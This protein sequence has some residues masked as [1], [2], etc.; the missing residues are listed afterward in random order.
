MPGIS[1]DRL[2]RIK[3]SAE[4]SIKSGGHPYPEDVT[5]E[6]VIALVNFVKNAAPITEEDFRHLV[7][8][9]NR[10]EVFHNTAKRLLPEEEFDRITEEAEEIPEPI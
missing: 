7:Y 4:M 2:E 10:L 3:K 6:E 8:E 5:Y 1:Y 9:N